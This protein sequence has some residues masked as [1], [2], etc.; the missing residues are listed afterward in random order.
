MP[1]GWPPEVNPPGSEGWETTAAAWLLDLVPEYRHP[2]ILAYIARHVI[3]GAVEAARQGYR[4]TP[5]SWATLSY[6][7]PST[8]R[9]GPGAPKASAWPPLPA[10]STW[11][12]APCGVRHSDSS[13]YAGCTAGGSPVHAQSPAGTPRTPAAPAAPT[14]PCRGREP[15]SPQPP[16]A[17]AQCYDAAFDGSAPL[18]SVLIATGTAG[19][20][21]LT[22]L[23]QAVRYPAGAANSGMHPDDARSAA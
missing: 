19:F 22:R 15:I 8:P 9:S 11:W 21:T 7:M 23:P 18:D 5:A 17:P 4:A 14:A 10:R 3:A 13:S 6:R 1:A 2:V 16:P 20:H 12:S